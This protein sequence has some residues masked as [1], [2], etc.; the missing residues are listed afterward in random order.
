MKLKIV[1]AMILAVCLLAGCSGAPK[2]EDS[3][4]PATESSKEESVKE[5]SSAKPESAASD[6]EEDEDE[7]EAAPESSETE[8][9]EEAE[10]EAEDA[11]DAESETS[12]EASGDQT[13]SVYKLVSEGAPEDTLLVLINEPDEAFLYATRITDE[14]DLT[15]QNRVMMIPRYEHSTI[16]LWTLKTEF[17]DDGQ[18]AMQVHDEL[19]Y[20]VADSS[21]ETVLMTSVERIEDSARYAVEIITPEG[22]GEYYF[23]FYGDNLPQTEFITAAKG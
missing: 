2:K 16:R 11:E 3:K 6:T 18:T 14:F 7:E 23:N 21:R 22:E 17:D 20:E 10:D 4:A 5:E 9:P 1:L 19:L 15:T 8:E 12:E 13:N